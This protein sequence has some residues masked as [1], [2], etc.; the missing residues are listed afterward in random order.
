MQSAHGKQIKRPR[1]LVRANERDLEDEE[2]DYESEE[3]G[4]FCEP[5]EQEFDSHDAKQAH[6]NSIHSV[7]KCTD[8]NKTFSTSD[9][10]AT[11]QLVMHS[12]RNGVFEGGSSGT[13]QTIRMNTS[14]TVINLQEDEEEDESEDEK[15]EGDNPDESL[16]YS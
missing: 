2:E 12:S 11:H 6:M 10:W 13:S 14:K 15:G 1:G 8:C 5:C 3:E 4:Y 16:E 7:Y 9:A